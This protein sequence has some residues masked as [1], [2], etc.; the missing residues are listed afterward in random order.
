MK[1][2]VVA[3]YEA[4]KALAVKSG[5]ELKDFITYVTDALRQIVQALRNALTFEDNF[6]CQVLTVAVKN[7]T[8]QEIN[9]G[10]R[11]PKHLICTRSFDSRYPVDSFFWEVNDENRVEVT[12]GFSGS[13]GTTAITLTLIA[14][15]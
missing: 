9:T 15:F 5:Q 4:S 3:A 2:T 1:L 11:T 8:A 7:S 12:V 6:N 13:P 14:F 10:L